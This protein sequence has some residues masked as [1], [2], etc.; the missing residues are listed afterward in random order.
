MSKWRCIVCCN[1]KIIKILPPI[2]VNCDLDKY[3]FFC[4]ICGRKTV[5]EKL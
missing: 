2:V 4:E 5:H 3:S 1:I